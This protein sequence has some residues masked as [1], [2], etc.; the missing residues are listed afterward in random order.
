LDSIEGIRKLPATQVGNHPSCITSKDLSTMKFV[1]FGLSISSSW[2]NGHATLLRGLFKAL[3]KRGHHI[4]FFERD[5]PYYAPHRDLTEMAGVHLELYQDWETAG[6]AAHRELMDAD[7]GMVTSY[8]PDGVA[9]SEAVFASGTRRVFYD[10]DTPVTLQRLRGGQ[11][12]PYIGARGLGDF[13]LVLSYTGGMAVQELR[14][15]LGA[16]RVV[17]LYG[18]VDPDVHRPA[19]RAE[20]YRGDLSYFGTYSEDRQKALEQLFVEPARKL[21]ER[22]FV[23]GG[24][25][26][27]HVFPWT[28]NIFFVRHIPPQEHSSFYCS[29]KL[30]LNVTRGPMAEMGYC[31]SGRLFEAAACGVPVLTDEW[32]GLEQFFEPGLEILTARSGDDAVA[33]IELP[34]EELGKIS[35]AARVRVLEQHTA[36]HRAIE[37]ERALESNSKGLPSEFPPNREADEGARLGA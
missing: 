26:Y 21:P 4:T 30:T 1:V 29:S 22:R 23:M 31:P 35:R 8:C 28:E 9:A 5:T 12:L 24:A 27:P 16:R 13:D 2:G 15:R 20:A 11:A 18:S 25:L 6:T 34:I 10:L 19:A 7:I 3:V 32:E 14:D 17:P 33:A 36:E 37:L